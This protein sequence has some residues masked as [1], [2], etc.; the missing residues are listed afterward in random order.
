MANYFYTDADGQQQGPVGIEQLRELVAEGIIKPDTHVDTGGTR[1]VFAKHI[2]RLFS[3][4]T[5]NTKNPTAIVIAIVAIL[6]FILM[7]VPV[8][9]TCGWCEGKGEGCRICK[10]NGTVFRT[11]WSRLNN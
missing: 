6:A 11:V 2:P 8:P 9:W 3:D 10:G 1:L 5:A 4:D 7:F